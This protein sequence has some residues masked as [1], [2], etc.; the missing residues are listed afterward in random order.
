MLNPGQKVDSQLYVSVHCVK[1]HLMII[2][3]L[4][5]QDREDC[6]GV[7]FYQSN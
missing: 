3:Y 7:C 4:M 2:S 6:Y 5:Q 1:T